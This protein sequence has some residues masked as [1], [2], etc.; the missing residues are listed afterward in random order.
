[1][2]LTQ[3]NAHNELWIRE[4]LPQKN[5]LICTNA[6]KHSC[7]ITRESILLYKLW[8]RTSSIET[9]L[10]STV[11]VGNFLTHTYKGGSVESP[12]N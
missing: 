5:S 4:S 12:Q 7:Y 3:Y 1:M 10:L 8:D 11:K 6:C 2:K 9:T